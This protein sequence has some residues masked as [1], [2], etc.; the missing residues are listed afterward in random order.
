VTPDLVAG[1][2]IRLVGKILPPEDNDDVHRN[3]AIYA[4][5]VLLCS[6]IQMIILGK[7]RSELQK[8]LSL[9]D[10]EKINFLL[11]NPITLFCCLPCLVCQVRTSS[12]RVAAVCCE[13]VSV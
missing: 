7:N 10:D 12:R 9:Y 8:K 11:Y 2:L 1:L 13:R 6:T 5:I 4:G 3:F